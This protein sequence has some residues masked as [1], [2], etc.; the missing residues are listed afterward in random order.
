MDVVTLNAGDRVYGTLPLAL[1][2]RVCALGAE[3]WHLD[4]H[5][6]A[7]WRG[8]EL[9]PEELSAAGARFVRYDIKE[10]D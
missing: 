9:T 10:I 6:P 7:A 2:A 3:Y 4:V 8:R 1:A 5:L